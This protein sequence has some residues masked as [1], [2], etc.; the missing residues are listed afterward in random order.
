MNLTVDDINATVLINNA[1]VNCGNETNRKM[2][3]VIDGN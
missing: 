1:T 2:L 3:H